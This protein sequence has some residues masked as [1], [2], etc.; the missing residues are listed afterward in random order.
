M[1][2]LILAMAVAAAPAAQA[3]TVNATIPAG[4]LVAI[5]FEL[6]GGATFLDLTTNGSTYA[7]AGG[8]SDTVI[9]LFGGA[10]PGAALLASDDDDGVMGRSFL[11][12]GAPGRA[13]PPGVAAGFFDTG[14]FTPDGTAPGAGIYTLVV[15]G[16]PAPF[17]PGVTLGALGSSGEEQVIE[18][19]LTIDTDG[20]LAVGSPAAVVPIPLPATGALLGG[21]L[22]LIGAGRMLGRRNT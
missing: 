3:A 15:S 17:A 22:A 16:F 9:G 10:G 13:T 8:A 5:T 11:S 6:G 7:G 1:R 4:G 18:L 20:E 21:L 14:T 2:T 19:V 12:F